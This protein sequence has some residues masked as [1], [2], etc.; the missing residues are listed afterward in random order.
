MKEPKE[1]LGIWSLCNHGDRVILGIPETSHLYMYHGLPG[2]CEGVSSAD[3]SL[4][5]VR[6]ESIGRLVL[7]PKVYCCPG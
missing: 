5:Y 2:R 3:E 4:V 1:Q 7:V 6:L